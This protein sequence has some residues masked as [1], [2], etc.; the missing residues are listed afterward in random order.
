MVYFYTLASS[1]RRL[2]QIQ[3]VREQVAG[4]AERVFQVLDTE[5]EITDA[6]DAS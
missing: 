2:T 4:A 6:P 3:A 1:T 5:P